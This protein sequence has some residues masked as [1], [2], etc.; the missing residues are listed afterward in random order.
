M[1]VSKHLKKNWFKYM[2]ETV[3]VIVGVLIAFSLNDWNESIK[4]RRFEVQ[5][6]KE[7]NGSLQNNV[8]Y[9]ERAIRRNDE[10]RRSCDLIIEYFDSELPYHDSLDHHFS[11]S[12]FWFY[13]SLE[14]T[15]YESLKSYGLHL[16]SNDSIREKLGDIYEWT[17]IDLFSQRQDEYF[18]GTVAPLLPDWFE[19][20]DFFGDMKPLDFDNLQNS[21]SY[22]HIL[23]T[24]VA[25]RTAQIDLYET[26]KKSRLQLMQMINNELQVLE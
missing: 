13:P 4:E 9:L 18:Y 11:T 22:R 24:M 17:F 15:A 6:L 14:N 5:M 20:H 21:N 12:L 10:A 19:S 25:Q 8:E 1:N 7:L 26:S 2:L 3:V 16:I 23:R